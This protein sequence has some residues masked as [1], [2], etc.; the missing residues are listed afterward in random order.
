MCWGSETEVRRSRTEA[1]SIEEED[2][3]RVGQGMEENERSDTG[4]RKIEM[5]GA[6]QKRAR[7]YRRREKERER[8]RERE[9]E[10]K[11]EREK[12][13]SRCC[14]EKTKESV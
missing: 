8:G 12:L 10:R 4:E 3:A 1:V 7:E 11:R 5:I 6:L 14:V 2:T 9:K 13:T